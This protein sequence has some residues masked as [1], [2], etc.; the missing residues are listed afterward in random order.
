MPNKRTILER[1]KQRK[2]LA[3]M[4]PMPMPMPTKEAVKAANEGEKRVKH[5]EAKK[6]REK[7]V[8][9]KAAKPKSKK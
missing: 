4:E 3:E 9:K 6:P 2:D 7:R 5:A 1:T 8:E